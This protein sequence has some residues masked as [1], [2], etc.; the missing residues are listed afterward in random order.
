MADLLPLEEAQARLLALGAPLAAEEAAL[1]AAAGRFLAADVFARLSVPPADVSAMDGWAVRIADLPG[2]LR[3]VGVS[4]A[5]QPFAGCIRPGEAVR[6]LTGGHLPDGADTVALQEEMD[7]ADGLLRLRGRGF[8]SV[9]R[10]VRRAGQD[11]AKGARVARA[12]ERLTPPRI[13]LLAAT[14]HAAVRVRRRPRVAL[15]ATGSELVPPGAEPGPGRIVSSNG[16]MLE[17]LLAAEGAEVADHGIVADDREATARAIAAAAKDADLL[18]TIGG[19][20]VGDHDLVRPALL[21]LGGSIDFWRIA[22]RPGKPL[23][24]GRLGGTVVLG[25]PGNPVSAHV[26]AILFAV[27]LLRHMAGA[28]DPLPQLET[29]RA[30][31]AL[32]PGGARRDFQRATLSWRDGEPWVTPAPVQDSAMLS[33]LA[34]A[35][36]LLVRHEGAPAAAVGAR[37][38]V[39]RL[40]CP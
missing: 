12:G 21:G 37:V 28:A 35:D 24:A 2:P 11:A 13:G 14:G 36:V 1:G 17:A 40:R 7:E 34:A 31:V 39:L 8:G 30:A 10:H 3:P 32:A 38:P 15:L 23:L 25:L 27:P 20:S 29:A 33:V 4:A 22:L 19:A 16:V 18:L 26:C 5:G 6:I 9:G